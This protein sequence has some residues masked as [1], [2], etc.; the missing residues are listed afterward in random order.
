[1]SVEKAAR[2]HQNENIDLKKEEGVDT[3]EKKKVGILMKKKK[4]R[5]LMKKKKGADI[6]ATVV[7]W[8]ATHWQGRGQ[9][10]GQKGG[11]QHWLYWPTFD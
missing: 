7:C 1:M 11:C 6:D 4:A 8:W 9:E 10:A 2:F 5:I 3:D